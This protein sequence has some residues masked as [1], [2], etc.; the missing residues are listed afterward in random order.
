[1]GH[2]KVWPLFPLGPFISSHHLSQGSFFLIRRDVS[3]P[4]LKT[5]P[6]CT[7]ES[8]QF[9]P[10][11]L[12]LELTPSPHKGH[13]EN[14]TSLFFIIF[15]YLKHLLLPSKSYTRRWCVRLGRGQRDAGRLELVVVWDL[16]KV[17]PLSQSFCK[18]AIPSGWPV[19]ALTLWGN[20]RFCFS[21]KVSY[22][23]QL[24]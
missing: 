9:L 7:N 12:V 18:A 13:K 5:L 3:L 8:L 23:F 16:L 10:L 1:M 11:P 19:S 24:I 17:L 6:S 2:L 20:L 4:F 15:S 22:Q 21:S 14:E